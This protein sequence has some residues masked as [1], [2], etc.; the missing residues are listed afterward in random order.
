M[1][2]HSENPEM[3]G[4]IEQL[5]ARGVRSRPLSPG[6]EQRILARLERAFENVDH[7]DVE[8]TA[9][10][11]RRPA[12]GR[13]VAIAAIAAVA[14]LVTLAVAVFLN[15]GVSD[16]PASVSPDA[17]DGAH[18]DDD[19][20]AAA[21]PIGTVRSAL[22]DRASVELFR[23]NSD[24]EAYWRLVTL[25]EFDGQTFRLPTSPLS[26]VYPGETQL[27]GR[28][29]RQQIEILGLTGSLMP[30]A[31][32]PYQVAPNT[33]VRFNRDTGSL[34][35]VGDLVSEEHYTIVSVR[36]E[37]TPAE[38]RASTTDNPPDEIFLG[39]PDDLPGDISDL[40]AEVAAG[41]TTDYDR[42]V[43]L[44]DWLR[45]NFDYSTDVP[46]GSGSN[47]IEKFLQIRKG[48]CE[49]FAAT[50]AV[51]ARTLGIPSRVAV[52]YTPG[53]L[54][55][56]GWYVVTGR[57][58]HAWPEVWFDG[59]GWIPF[60]PTPQRTLPLDPAQGSSLDALRIMPVT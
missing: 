35:K 43:A 5:S 8:L 21:S 22:T 19:R 49:Q 29:I 44:Q 15:A 55:P 23:V 12:S 34:V 11:R 7:T 20:T 28:T 47:A 1:R 27:S 39:L 54:Q 9:F 46:G 45:S 48:Y 57:D 4:A 6:G 26:G 56:D 50:F 17:T 58:S 36:P 16:P 42:L 18:E 14:V 38:L 37:A 32:D 40:A 3:E 51:M 13:P 53:A 59:L 30:A 24:A 52:G 25:P 2:H 60:E 33:D 31:A 10:D 41:A